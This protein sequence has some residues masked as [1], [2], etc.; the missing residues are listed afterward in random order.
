MPGDRFEQIASTGG[1]Y[2]EL[3][4]SQP[5]L[6]SLGLK[7][8]FR[9]AVGRE[10]SSKIGQVEVYRTDAKDVALHGTPFNKDL[11]EVTVG[12][13]DN[14]SLFEIASGIPSSDFDPNLVEFAE[15]TV[16]FWKWPTSSVP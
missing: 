7:P 11:Y 2:F 12:G 5:P 8:L 14:Q 3:D 1:G 9:I 10:V 16:T 6:F 4:V 13:P 15:R